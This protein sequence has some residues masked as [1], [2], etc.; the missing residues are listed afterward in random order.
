MIESVEA[1]DA[2]RTLSVLDS[3]RS[4]NL[5]GGLVKSGRLATSGPVGNLT[6]FDLLAFEF[7]TSELVDPIVPLDVLDPPK[8]ENE[9]EPIGTSGPVGNL[10]GIDLL[11]LE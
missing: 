6:E 4:Q 11:A 5:K 8:P 10:T 7:P 3:P 1:S 2:V 9:K